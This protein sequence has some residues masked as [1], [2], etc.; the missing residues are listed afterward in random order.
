MINGNSLLYNISLSVQTILIAD[1]RLAEGQLFS[2]RLTDSQIPSSYP[3]SLDVKGK[4]SSKPGYVNKNTR[5]YNN[6]YQVTYEF[7]NAI[8]YWRNYEGRGG[9]NDCN[10]APDFRCRFFNFFTTSDLTRFQIRKEIFYF[11]P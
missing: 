9:R 11:N 10:T 3:R 8:M 2:L 1:A 6:N 7:S 4:D 5:K